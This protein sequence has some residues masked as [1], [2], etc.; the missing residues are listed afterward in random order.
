MKTLTVEKAQK[1]FDSILSNI[2]SESIQINEAGKP[3]AVF[4]SVEQF[5]IN[6]RIKLEVQALKIDY[7]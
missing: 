2:H 6:Q 5:E 7:K 1:H 4:I 3:I